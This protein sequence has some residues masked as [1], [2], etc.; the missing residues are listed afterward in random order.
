MVEA[1]AEHMQ[2]QA[3]RVSG[4]VFWEKVC[5]VV[6]GG[7]WYDRWPPSLAVTTDQL[8]LRFN[9]AVF[10]TAVEGHPWAY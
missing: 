9:S 2:Q 5:W 8:Q 6:E 10:P 7:M 3:L 1:V 4:C